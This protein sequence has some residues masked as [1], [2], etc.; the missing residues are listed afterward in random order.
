MRESHGILR[1]VAGIASMLRES[2]GARGAE[3]VD[4]E[5]LMQHMGRAGVTMIL[6]VD[7]ERTKT[8]MNPWTLVLSGP[9]LGERGL[10]R[11]DSP[12][13]EF[14]LEYCLN[15]LRTCPGD[16]AWLDEYI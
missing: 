1:D 11:T 3:V 4:L 2:D 7:H 9:G 5:H 12:A 16:W 13:L 6:K 8:G 14:C 15:E 10:I